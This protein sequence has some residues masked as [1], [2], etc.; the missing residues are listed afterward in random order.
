MRTYIINKVFRNKKN[1]FYILLLSILNLLLIFVINYKNNFFKK[2]YDDFENNIQGR[3]ILIFPNDIGDM[4]LE[5][6]TNFKY[7]VEKIRNIIHIVAVNNCSECNSAK[8]K[9]GDEVINI[10]LKYGN[11]NTLP[12]NIY[13]NVLDESDTHVIICPY[14]MKFKSINNFNDYIGKDFIL[15]Y[16]EMSRINGVLKTVDI[17]NEKFKLI[18]LYDHNQN[19]M[20]DFDCYVSAKDWDNIY[21]LSVEPM[22]G[23]DVILT[24]EVIVDSRNNLEYV[25]NELKKLGYKTESKLVI[26]Y[27][28]A[29]NVK[30]IFYFGVIISF[31]CIFIISIF[32]TKKKTFDD[33]YDI[34]MLKTFGYSN[35]YIKGIYMLQILFICILSFVISSIFS[36]IIYFIIINFYHGD[37]N[38]LMY[39]L[40]LFLDSYLITG[41]F[42]ILVPMFVYYVNLN[43]YIKIETIK[44]LKEND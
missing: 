35:L 13:G 41:F 39:H 37:Y 23:N 12:S 25:K 18:G 34:G 30:S 5:E 43:K 1:Y 9:Y 36:F 22:N 44:L 2:L 32:Y 21:K 6:F 40:R 17:K 10:N 29:N 28:T 8:L 15:E 31:I 11:K 16:E 20:D 26:D 3:T 19:Y 14:L 38:N 4:T 33:K 7:D 27:E 24:M 42:S